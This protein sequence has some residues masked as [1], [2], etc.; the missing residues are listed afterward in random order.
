MNNRANKW[1][2]SLDPAA[3]FAVFFIA[4]GSIVFVPVGAFILFDVTDHTYFVIQMVC[5]SVLVAL[6]FLRILYLNA[7]AN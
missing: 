1:F 5:Y 4:L 3:R 7:K 6:A 2:D